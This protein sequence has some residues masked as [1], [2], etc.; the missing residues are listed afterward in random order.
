LWVY[1]PGALGVVLPFLV[2]SAAARQMP[3]RISPW[4]NGDLVSLPGISKI[5]WNA[6]TGLH[7]ALLGMFCI[8]LAELRLRR[9][10]AV[11]PIHLKSS[12]PQAAN[13]SA[14]TSDQRDWTKFVWFAITMMN[15]G[16]LLVGAIAVFILLGPLDTAYFRHTHSHPIWLLRILAPTVVAAVILSMVLAFA[17]GCRWEVLRDSFRLPFPEYFAIAF[18]LTVAIYSLPRMF[19]NIRD[20]SHWIALPSGAT[21]HAVPLTLVMFETFSMALVEEVAWRGYLQPRFIARY[22]LY[23]G[24]FFVGLVWAA[25]HFSGDFNE[26]T[27]DANVIRFLLGRMMG[28]I[29]IGSALSWLTLRS[30]SVL[31]AALAHFTVNGI[32]GAAY[33]PALGLWALVDLLL[34]RFWPPRDAV[35]APSEPL[36]REIISPP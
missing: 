11:L 18:V 14:P 35:S 9:G 36:L 25:F 17:R 23:R 10:L 29:L 24:V 8:A 27:S 1:L 15:Q 13:I 34:F 2:V 7:F 4:G 33:L 31:P 3:A 32:G 28:G 20:P 12:P 30:K 26:N 5:V 22:G 16:G 21:D 6:G 19:A